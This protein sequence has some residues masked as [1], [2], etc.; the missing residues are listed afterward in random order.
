MSAAQ[1]VQ[2]L[3]RKT[4]K[5]VI[6]L[7][8]RTRLILVHAIEDSKDSQGAS[9]NLATEVDSMASVVLWGIGLF[10]RPSA[11][12]GLGGDFWRRR[13]YSRGY[14]TANSAE[15]N[16]VGGGDGSNRRTG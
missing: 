6:P 15:G 14:N 7:A 4:L 5:P 2:F 1:L 8:G 11:A 16:D 12:E 13:G 10:V 9:S 3:L